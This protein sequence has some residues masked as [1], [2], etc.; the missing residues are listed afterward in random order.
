MPGKRDLDPSQRFFDQSGDVEQ[1]HNGKTRPETSNPAIDAVA[2]TA[3]GEGV[4]A[5][6][7][8]WD[9]DA[10]RTEDSEH[11]T[12]QDADIWDLDAL[13]LSQDFDE[14]VVGKKLLMTVPV[15]K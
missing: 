2:L 14:E 8:A 11:S 15:R 6:N 9:L 7:D 12:T 13:R 1:R 5:S 3:N 10:L 4:E